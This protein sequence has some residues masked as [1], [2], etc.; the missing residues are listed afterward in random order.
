MLENIKTMKIKDALFFV[1][2]LL[3]TSCQTSTETTEKKATPPNVILIMTDDQGYG[4]FSLHGND[5][6]FTPNLDV[7][8]KNGVQFDRFYVSP[9]CAPTRASLLT[10]RYHLRTGTTWVTHRKEVMRSEEVTIAEVFKQAGYQT[11]IFGKWHNG[12]QYPNHPNGQGFDEFFGFAAG[13]WNNYFD[14]HLENN[15]QKVETEGYITDVLTDKAIDFIKK[16]KDE[17]F[18]CYIPYNAPHSPFQVPDKYFDKYKKMGLTDKNACVYGMNENI[19]DNFGRVMETLQS[20]DLE[21]NTIVVFLTDN[22]PNGNRFNGNMKGRKAQV[23]EGGVRVPLFMQWKNHLPKGKTV[24]ELAAHIDILPTLMDLC[25]IENEEHLPFDGKSLVALLEKDNTSWEERPIY[26]IQN[27]GTWN[28]FPAS[29]RNN[30]YRLVK[31]H[32]KNILLYDMIADPSQTENI[33]NKQPKITKKLTKDL[34]NWFKSVTKNGITPPLAEVGHAESPKVILPAPEAKLSGNLAFEGGRGW[35]N[36][37]IKNWS[38]TNDKAI[39]T[40]NVIEEGNYTISVEYTATKADV[41]LTA[42]VGQ[43][44]S[45][46]IQ[47]AFNPSF[48]ESPD[49]V[50]RGEVYEKPWKTFEIGTVY[51]TKGEQQIVLYGDGFSG[52]NGFCV[53]GVLVERIN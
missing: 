20:L 21:E 22:G 7:F 24:T 48:L 27:D 36:D 53:K 52:E 34:E 31:D 32:L 25:Q 46:T 49:R 41:N 14:T 6:C 43:P 44:I 17:P 40:I 28:D 50:K 10:G 29:V 39:W 18:L 37:W 23:D 15:G 12:E 1:L 26:S 2:I 38:N 3:L 8:A 13:H 5:S 16:N 47:A 4:D 42:I 35:A 9:V 30:R 19:D 51:L 11:G 45:N 33:A